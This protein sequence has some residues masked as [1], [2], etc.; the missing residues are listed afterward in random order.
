MCTT[1]LHMK[2][3][4]ASI[5]FMLISGAHSLDRCVQAEKSPQERI[6][7]PETSPQEMV[8]QTGTSSE[9]VMPAEAS[10]PEVVEQASTASNIRLYFPDDPLPHL[11]LDTDVSMVFSS[12]QIDLLGYVQCW[13]HGP[14]GRVME[15][16]IT[17][18]QVSEAIYRNV[19]T[20][21][22]FNEIYDEGRALIV[23]MLSEAMSQLIERLSKLKEILEPLC[24]NLDEAS[25]KYLRQ[26]VMDDTGVWHEVSITLTELINRLKQ[27]QGNI[28][29]NISRTHEMPRKLVTRDEK[30]AI[31]WPSERLDEG[32]IQTNTAAPRI[33]NL[34]NLSRVFD[35]LPSSAVAFLKEESKKDDFMPWIS[36]NPEREFD[37]AVTIF[38]LELC[39]A[40]REHKAHMDELPAKLLAF[41]EKISQMAVDGTKNLYR[42]RKGAELDV[43]GFDLKDYL[44]YR[45]FEGLSNWD[46]DTFEALKEDYGLSEG[47]YSLV[48]SYAD[49]CYPS[50][51]SPSPSGSPK[52]MQSEPHQAPESLEEMRDEDAGCRIK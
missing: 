51:G 1:E 45:I 33:M 44:E 4:K 23:S 43:E 25:A 11:I 47:G 32:S 49:S 37:Y 5:V 42:S 40:V 34:A 46:C 16:C 9:L 52:A 28:N 17:I 39:H 27:D 10:P 2:Y 22:R 24:D 41:T 6:G 29:P 13:R 12:E 26:T 50:H 36:E 21:E 20:S 19:L 18:N 7:Q 30:L 31:N 38:Y 35:M 14:I 8:E 48:Y 15:Y 3:A